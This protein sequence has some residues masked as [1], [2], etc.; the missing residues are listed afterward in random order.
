MADPTPTEDRHPVCLGKQTSLPVFLPLPRL[1]FTM[2]DT[3]RRQRSVDAAAGNY[4]PII[5]LLHAENRIPNFLILLGHLWIGGLGECFF[6][7]FFAIAAR[8]SLHCAPWRLLCTLAPIAHG[9]TT[10]LFDTRP[11]SIPVDDV[12]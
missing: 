11:K 12:A 6:S 9:I 5:Q 8:F 3:P 7:I 1:Q 4:P 10:Y 2:S